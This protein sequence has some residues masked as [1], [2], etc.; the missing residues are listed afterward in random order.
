MKVFVSLKNKR[1]NLCDSC[2]NCFADCKSE[3]LVF[4]NGVGNDNVIVCDAYASKTHI[5][6]VFVERI[7]D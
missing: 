6:G 4:G 1:N 3:D 5:D 7:Y 2:N